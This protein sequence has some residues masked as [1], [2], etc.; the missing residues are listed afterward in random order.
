MAAKCCTKQEILNQKDF[1]LKQFEE[2]PAIL[3]LPIDNERPLVKSN[4]GDS[5]NFALDKQK[6][7]N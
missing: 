7:Y 6:P 1:W 3:Q 5:I 4:A 2:E